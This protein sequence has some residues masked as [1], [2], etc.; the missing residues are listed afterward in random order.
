MLHNRDLHIT[1]LLN[2]KKV[3]IESEKV[4]IESVLLEK[5]KDFAIKTAVHIRR[6]FEKF[7]Y[8][9]VFGRS[10]VIE[11]LGLK[12]SSASKLLSNLV[13]ADIIEPVSGYEKENEEHGLE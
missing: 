4:D 12:N 8:D 3:D 6:M 10:A 1:G 2:D 7:G 13:Q 11:L 5:G 9:E